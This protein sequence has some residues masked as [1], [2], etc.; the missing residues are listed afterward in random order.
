MSD[1]QPS[2]GGPSL[3]DGWDLEGLLSGKHARVAEGMRPVA[4]ALAA[5]R[6]APVPAELAGEAVARAMFRQI[7]LAS[8]SERLGRATEPVPRTP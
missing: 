6:A 2:N 7:M 4:G 1:S 8:E 3:Y 5:L